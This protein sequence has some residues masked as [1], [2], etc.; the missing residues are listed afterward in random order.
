MSTK[1]A[2]APPETF[3]R[4]RDSTPLAVLAD[5]PGDLATRHGLVFAEGLDDL[6]RFLF[7]QV[8]LSDGTS[9]VLLKHDG[10]PNPGTVVRMDALGDPMRMRNLLVSALGLGP[11]DV[12][13][14]SAGV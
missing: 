2:T 10:D 4:S 3:F 14:W 11:G 6:D 9:V 1:P 7:A 5:E 8:V 13:W 12:L